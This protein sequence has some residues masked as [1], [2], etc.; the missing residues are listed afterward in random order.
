MPS[1][2]IADVKA[3]VRHFAKRGDIPYEVVMNTYSLTDEIHRLRATLI[4]IVSCLGPDLCECSAPGDCGLRE[5]AHCA[6][7]LAKQALDR[8]QPYADRSGY[9][10][11]PA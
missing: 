1:V 4:E 7:E 9:P 5:E 2:D 3:R 11:P 10:T 8:S 6:L